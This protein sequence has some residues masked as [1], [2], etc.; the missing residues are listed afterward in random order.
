MVLPGE[1]IEGFPPIMIERAKSLLKSVFGYDGFI[2]LQ[3]DVIESV[4]KGR[5]CLAVMP[6]GG[7]KSLCYQIPALLFDGLTI[8]VS[9]L[10]SLMKDQVEQLD[11]VGIPAALLNSSISPETYRRSVEKV[12]L[13]EAKLLYVAPETLLKSHVLALL[14]SIS[15]SCLTIDEAHCISEWGHDFRPEYRQLATVR[16]RFPQAVCIALTA[17]ATPRVRK[18]IQSSL[19]FEESS[20]F[21]ASF[22][23]ENLLLRVIPKEKPLRQTVE[24]LRKYPND[25]GII[26]CSTR[27]HVDDLCEALLS[28]DFSACPYHAGLPDEERARNQERFVRDEVRIVVATVA[29]GMGI[30]KS[31]V[32]F[33]LHYDLPKNIESYYQEIGRAGRDGMRAECVLLFSYGDIRQI[34]YFI[35]QKEG[36]EKRA[37]NIQLTAMLQFAESEVCRR[38]PLLGYFGEIFPG[39]ACG[40]CDNCLAGERAMQDITIPAQ[41]F[42]SCVRRTGEC[43]GTAHIIDVLR[44]SQGKKV[45]KFG[46]EKLSTYGIGMELSRGQWRQV[47]RQL[48][49]KG[50]MVQHPEV[51]GLSLTERAWN[52][53]RG[54]ETVW[55][56]LDESA[57]AEDPPE[58]SSGDKLLQYAPQLFEALRRKRKELADAANVPPYVVFSDRTLAE[59]AAYIPRNPEEMLGIHGVGRAKL[60]RYGSIFLEVLR[61]YCRGHA[62]RIDSSAPPRQT[63]ARR[64]GVAR[65]MKELQI[66]EAFNAGWAVET[67]A[68][69]FKMKESRILD[70]LLRYYE[71]GNPLRAEGFLPLM[72]LPWDAAKRAVKTFA[73]IGPELLRPVYDALGGEIGY[74]DLRVLRLYYLA[75]Q[76]P[77]GGRVGDGT[78]GKEACSRRIVCLANSR[79]YSG[80]C[81]AGKELTESGVGAWIRPVSREG[82]GELPMSAIVMRKGEIPK[83]L[84]I[85][86][87]P[88]VGAAPH[89]YQSENHVLGEERFGWS[90]TWE[91]SRVS[92]LCDDPERLWINGY[93][94]QAGLN[95]RMPVDLT[96]GSLS[97]SLL[98]IRPACLTLTVERGT[99]GLNKVRARFTYK[100]E[101]YWITVTDPVIEA[102]YLPKEVGSYPVDCPEPYITVSI[103]EPFEG[104]C[105]KLAAALIL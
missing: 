37:A 103:S 31:N 81:I 96:E 29:F 59:M 4:L 94:S 71:G 82:N 40:M 56:R 68:A 51:G 102:L 16:A 52:V 91:R 70:Y 93:S 85:L 74:E 3:K 99:R 34:K 22:N 79:K 39:Y 72:A 15:I 58:K 98:L 24:F 43:F 64:D 38:I 44:G 75:L 32:R 69:R 1:N 41:K 100:G 42:L 2:S 5:D 53:L 7:G 86:T 26:Y 28:R 76:R 89:A 14:D 17:T 47:A 8:V 13:G 11:Q 54:K 18:D 63:L 36:I 88:L 83:L 21:V 30:D 67:L 49:H 101:P 57:A 33:V 12:R 10:I 9:P 27:K 77:T 60:D 6:T 104:F 45:F 90:G 84:D 50:L 92:E 25:S 95:D 20:E 80:R 65:A 97:S 61:D 35:A 55:G 62:D 23:R 78:R 19:G 46:H 105:Y 73:E 48:L 87:V 66:G